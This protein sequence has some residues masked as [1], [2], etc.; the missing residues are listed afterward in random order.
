MARPAS[1]A[2]P[3]GHRAAEFSVIVDAPRPG[4]ADALQPHGMGGS[5]LNF[6]GDPSRAQTAFTHANYERLRDV[7]RRYDPDNLFRLNHNI[8]P[9]A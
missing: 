6:L 3:T 8:T 1:N 9:A 2:G 7:K 5:F 4:L